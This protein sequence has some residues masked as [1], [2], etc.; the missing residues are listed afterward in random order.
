MKVARISF[1]ESLDI[2][3]IKWLNDYIIETSHL[4]KYIRVKT[5]EK[6]AR[7]AFISLLHSA[8]HRKEERKE[9]KP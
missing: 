3:I 6:K 8:K 9:R 2:L 7:K 5:K 4:L 1:N